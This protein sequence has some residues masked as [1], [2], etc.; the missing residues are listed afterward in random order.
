[1]IKYHNYVPKKKDIKHLFKIILICAIFTM[2]Q[3]R[4]HLI[5]D[6]NISTR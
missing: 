4:P 2:K 5:A 1:M 6:W 3:L